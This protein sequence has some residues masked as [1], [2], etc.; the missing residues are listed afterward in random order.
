[1][2]VGSLGW[3]TQQAGYAKIFVDLGPV[4]AFAF[5]EELEVL[6]LLGCSVKKAREPSQRNRYLAAVGEQHSKLVV[7]DRYLTSLR[8]NFDD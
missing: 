6:A 7:A 8:A 5:A 3:A 2:A 1:M 4:D